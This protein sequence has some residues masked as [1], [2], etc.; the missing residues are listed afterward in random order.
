MR[1]ARKGTNFKYQVMCI[2]AYFATAKSIKSQRLPKPCKSRESKK[3]GQDCCHE[4]RLSWS[5][6][7]ATVALATESSGSS[8]LYA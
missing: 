8:P 3:A 2:V 1:A 4:K 7:T 6:L 5:E